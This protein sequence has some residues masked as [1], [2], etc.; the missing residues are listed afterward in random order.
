MSYADRQC[1]L[2]SSTTGCESGVQ[3]PLAEVNEPS[4]KSTLHWKYNKPEVAKVTT[5]GAMLQAMNAEVN[6]LLKEIELQIQ[7]TRAELSKTK[8]SIKRPRQQDLKDEIDET[9]VSGGSSRR[10]RSVSVAYKVSEEKELPDNLEGGALDED[11]THRTSAIYRDVTEWL[12]TGTS[13]LVDSQTEQ[14]QQ[15]DDRVVQ[16]PSLQSNADTPYGSASSGNNYERTPRK[17]LAINGARKTT[18]VMC[19]AGKFQ[20]S[21]H[22]RTPS[23][24]SETN[25]SDD[26][27]HTPTHVKRKIASVRNSSVR[28]NFE[29]LTV[30]GTFIPP[31]LTGHN[32]PE[33]FVTSATQEQ[34]TV[35]LSPTRTSTEPLDLRKKGVA[36][37]FNVM[38]MQNSPSNSFVLV[39]EKQ[40][41]DGEKHVGSARQNTSSI[42][43]IDTAERRPRYEITRWNEYGHIHGSQWAR[44][45]AMYN[46][47]YQS[48]PSDDGNCDDSFCRASN[49]VLKA[50]DE[51]DEEVES[52]NESLTMTPSKRNRSDYSRQEVGWN[53]ILVTHDVSRS[54]ATYNE[55]CTKNH[56][57]IE[58][59]ASTRTIQVSGK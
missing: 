47:G 20:D 50:A 15:N 10:E 37:D 52:D 45:N 36:K 18:D 24:S 35:I 39:A 57:D 49:Y 55:H 38:T 6:E 16:S 51:V 48:L 41:Q 32:H 27:Q 17:T 59:I 22:S 25:L 19:S 34:T 23:T 14:Q 12:E 11:W 1:P 43:M 28:K 58:C 46:I 31:V 29:K 21:W 13:S 9:R 7:Q 3:Y 44:Y 26:A 40:I 4:V 56:T 30:S 53:A 33:T 2:T 42:S 8:S 5:D 54:A